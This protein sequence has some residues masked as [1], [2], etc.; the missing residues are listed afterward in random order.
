VFADVEGT[1]QATGRRVSDRFEVL[2]ATGQTLVMLDRY[3]GRVFTA[4][5]SATDHLY[6][7]RITLLAGEPARI[8]PVEIQL[9]AQPLADALPTLYAM[10]S[11]PGLQHIYI[12]GDLIMPSSTLPVDYAQMQIRR[13]EA[14]GVGRYA[15]HYLTASALIELANLQVESADLVIIATYAGPTT[16]PTATPLPSPP[17]TPE[18][19][20]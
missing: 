12:S 1:W 11:E 4:G 14:D 6:L 18:E 8:K 13:I 17:P 15:L 3:T 16:G 2:N 10:Q 7:N 9:Q 20:P 19:T 5:R